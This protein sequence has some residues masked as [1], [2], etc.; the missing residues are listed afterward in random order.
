[1]KVFYLLE[2]LVLERIALLEEFVSINN[3]RECFATV[4][5][6]ARPLLF[7]KG[8]EAVAKMYNIIEKNARKDSEGGK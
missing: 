1:V 7:G 2:Q 4:P 3:Y 6:P 5:I 8:S